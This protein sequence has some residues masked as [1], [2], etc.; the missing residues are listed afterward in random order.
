M[1]SEAQNRGLTQV[2]SGSTIGELLR[3]YW[4]PIAGVAEFEDGNDIRPVRLMGEDLVLYRDKRGVFGLVDRQCPH[5]RADLSYGFVE[6][7]GIRCNYHGW[8]FAADGSCIAQPYE[9]TANPK[10]KFKDKVRI[11]SYPVETKAGMVWAYMGPLPAPLVPDWEP[12]SWENGFAQVVIAEIPCNWLQCQE[13]SIDPVHFEWMHM[14]W[15]RRQKDRD[16]EYGPKHIEVGFDE[17]DYG[18]VYRRDREDLGKEHTMWTVGRTALWPNAFFLGD[19]FEYRVPIDDENTLSVSWI[20]NRVPKEQEPFVQGNIPAWRGPI[21]D[22]KTGRWISSHVMN[23]DFIAWVGQ[24]TIADR[25]KENLGTSDK[26]VA[27]LRRRLLSEAKVVAE[28]G[29]PKGTIRDPA[30]NV[31]IALPNPYR[32]LFE[33][34]LTLAEIRAHPVFGKHLEAFM[35]QAGQPPKVWHAFREAM[36]LPPTEIME[37]LP[38]IV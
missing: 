10:G 36:G 13:N 9:D 3:R 25:T 7:C 26:G 15:Q 11:K 19:H 28:G 38:D 16:A 17:F 22:E 37:I 29:D 31:A 12:F 30:V 6:Q 24:G 5:R 8:Q 4:M 20:F 18:F 23:Q 21:K 1:L 33:R 2:G 14:N 35:F 34:G 27:L 32:A